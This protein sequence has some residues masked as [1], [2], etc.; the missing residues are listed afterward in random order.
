MR[1]YETQE[2]L[3]F[4][5]MLRISWTKYVNN[6]ESYG[7]IETKR[8]LMLRIEETVD[9]FGRHGEERGI[10]ECDAHWKGND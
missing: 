1:K 4:R 3:L 8:T 5:G 9:I 6:E 2:M 10:V 7:D